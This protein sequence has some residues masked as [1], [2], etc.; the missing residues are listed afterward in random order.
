MRGVQIGVLFVLCVWLQP[1]LSQSS[2]VTPIHL[3][4]GEVLTFYLQTRMT[5]SPDNPL[6]ALPKGT[7]MRVRLLDAIDSSPEADGA[8]FRGLLDSP[9]T[10][11]HNVTL[12]EEHAEVRGLLVL[13][14]SRSHP[15]GFRYEL[16]L[17]GLTVDGKMQ[18]LTATLNPSFFEATKPPSPASKP[19]Q[20]GVS[21]APT[22]KTQRATSASPAP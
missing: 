17:T 13:L 15:E 19:E 9:L 20:E 4:A 1:L 10:D 11:S 7:M 6:D 22:P 16:L 3:P 8:A 2:S 5:P 12:A 21:P 18:D 14:R